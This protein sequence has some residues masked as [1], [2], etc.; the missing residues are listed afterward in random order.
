[1]KQMNL[2]SAGFLTSLIF[3]EFL[4]VIQSGCGNGN[5]NAVDSLSTGNDSLSFRQDTAGRVPLSTWR[6]QTVT[7]YEN[8]DTLP[9]GHETFVPLF[10]DSMENFP[11]V[12]DDGNTFRTKA[13]SF[14]EA[15][16]V[17]FMSDSREEFVEIAVSD[18]SADSNMMR[19]LVQLYNAADGVDLEG[20]VDKR[21]NTWSPNLLIWTSYNS[22]TK[23]ATAQAL[24]GFRIQ[25]MVEASGQKDP[26]FVLGILK[27][28]DI[29]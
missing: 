2:R 29:R 4:I 20:E 1:M 25:V 27:G 19:T 28:M 10:P 11:H 9:A 5:G 6:S 22:A 14:S 3:L 24:S 13:I 23:I 15:S 21:V 17:F 7:R 12:L 18:Y 16:R 8:D 26:E